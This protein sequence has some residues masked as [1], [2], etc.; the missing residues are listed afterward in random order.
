M[1]ELD[2]WKRIDRK[3]VF[4]QPEAIFE[5]EGFVA[6]APTSYGKPQKFSADKIRNAQIITKE[7]ENNITL[8]TI[9]IQFEDCIATAAVRS[10]TFIVQCGPGEMINEY[11]IRGSNSTVYFAQRDGSYYSI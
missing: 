1:I 11:Q 3:I 7:L 10:N 2:P 8:V 4:D 6:K 5:F 9:V